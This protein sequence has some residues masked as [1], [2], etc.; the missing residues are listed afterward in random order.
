MNRVRCTWLALAAGASLAT[1][2][3]GDRDDGRQPAVVRRADEVKITLGK[4]PPA[5]A[6]ESETP[7]AGSP[8][9][10][11]P[12]ASAEEVPSSPPEAP[13]EATN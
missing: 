5:A 2:C 11:I 1:G 6:P 13:P 9:E 8:M 7:K 12:E 10:R 4:E 3:S